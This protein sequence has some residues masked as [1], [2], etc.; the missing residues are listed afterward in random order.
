MDISVWQYAEGQ[1]H[2]YVNEVTRGVATCLF[3]FFG[4]E[5]GFIREVDLMVEHFFR[6][7]ERDSGA[8]WGGLDPEWVALLDR[9][10]ISAEE[11]EEEEEG[12]IAMAD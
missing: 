2:Y 12:D 10:T 1:F 6:Y 3:G 11:G 9:M 7:I 4:E 5:V 8:N